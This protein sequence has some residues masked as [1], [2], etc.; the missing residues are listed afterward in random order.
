MRL[1]P[2]ATS[3]TDGGGERNGSI[4]GNDSGDW[5]GGG[6]DDGDEDKDDDNDGSGDAEISSGLSGT[7]T[8]GGVP[9][10]E[11]KTAHKRTPRE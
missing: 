10:Q 7:S 9:A 5:D 11:I 1:S 8:T 3:S 2:T 4:D 6:K